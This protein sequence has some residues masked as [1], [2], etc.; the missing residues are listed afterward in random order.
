MNHCDHEATMRSY[1]AA[2]APVMNYDWLTPAQKE[3]VEEYGRYLQDEVRGRRVLEIACGT[4]YWT[5]CIAETADRVSAT[6]A[7]P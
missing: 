4:G 3:T 2:R 1:Y 5:Q 6:D 7:V